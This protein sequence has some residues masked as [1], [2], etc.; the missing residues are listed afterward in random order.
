VKRESELD[1]IVDVQAMSLSYASKSAA[2]PV[3]TDL[4][5]AVPRASWTCITGPSGSG[6][7][8]ILNSIAGLLRP[9]SGTVRVCGAELT[10]MSASELSRWRRTH[11]G[12]VFQFHHLFASLSVEENVG[13]PLVV[14]GQ[15]N[16]RYLDRVTAALDAVGLAALRKKRADELS[17][18]QQQRVAI[19]RAIVAN[20]DLIL[21]DEPTGNLD[22]DSSDELMQMFQALNVEFKKTIVMVTHDSAVAALAS[23]EVR[24]EKS[25]KSVLAES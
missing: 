8:T 19:A 9:T 1:L 24:L 17:G 20:P 22:R 11:I 10:D 23:S 6:K 13:I 16:T 5:L 2:L 3:I 4:N 18:G 12:Y 21:A 7:T 14:A 15:G 25:S